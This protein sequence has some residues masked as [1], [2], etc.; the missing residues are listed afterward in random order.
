METFK[1]VVL[2][3]EVVEPSLIILFSILI[4]IMIGKIIKRFSK[5]PA[6]R[7]DQKKRQTILTV[8]K[9]VIKYI[10][11]AI[12][13]LLI[14]NVY[15]IDTKAILASFGVIGAVL[16]LA[17][18]DLL[19]DIISGISILFEDQF[20]VGDWIEV[21]GFK[22][23]V[24]SL[25][26]KT[27]RIKAYTGETKIVSNRTLTEVTNFNMHS[28][29]AIVDI[30]VSYEENLEKVEKV[31]ST[32][33][34]E[35]QEKIPMLKGKIELLGVQSLGENGITYRIVAP[36]KSME[37]YGVERL[38]RKAIKQTLDKN[39]IIIPYPQVVIHNERV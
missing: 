7:V 8:L 16:G 11:L 38:L 21:G 30:E 28:S 24:I 27:T 12:D 39:H 33:C 15:G 4:Y 19:K 26:L 10:I 32:L 13:I 3:K 2:I 6:K 18:Q 20:R 22:G 25:G 35:E 5:M 17:M 9:S 31:L 37:Q 36:C 34:T 23:E 14:L 29:M 1:E